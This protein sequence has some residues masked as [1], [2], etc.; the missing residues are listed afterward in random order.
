[1]H[2]GLLP[3]SSTEWLRMIEEVRA[4]VYYLPGYVAACAQREGGEGF[5]FAATEAGK[6]WL[7]PLIIRAIPGHEPLVDAVSPYG[8]SGPLA[9]AP[10]DE[11][12]LWAA[13]ATE[14][15]KECLAERG[16][17]T[18]FIRLHPILN[19]NAAAISPDEVLTH[20]GSTVVVDLDRSDEQLW[21]DIR[22]NH[23]RHINR[24]RRSG[25]TVAMR[26]DPEILDLFKDM[27]LQTMSRVGASDYHVK[28]ADDLQELASTY[29]ANLYVCTVQRDEEIACIGLITEMDG[30]VE[31]HLSGTGQN[32]V[33]LG[34]SKLLL[35]HAIGWAKHRGNRFFHLGGG[36]GCTNDSLLH[37]KMG[38]SP[39]LLPFHSWDMVIDRSRYEALSATASATH[40]AGDFFPAYRQAMRDGGDVPDIEAMTVS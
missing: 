28:L 12:A 22:A 5:L 27:Y 25:F 35:H 34:P 3:S 26:N 4:D 19:R 6:I 2:A 18:A 20:R 33:E 15:L 11:A 24:L 38:F 14:R 29:K 37:F 30:L 40:R 36:V 39:E 31:Y 16:A 10:D 13:R 21:G 9:R 1:M 7:Q 8:Y 17:I 32:Y 23:R